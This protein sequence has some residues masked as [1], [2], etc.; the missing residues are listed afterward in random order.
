MPGRRDYDIAFVGLKPGEHEFHY[1]I[2]DKFFADRPEQEFKNCRAHVKLMLDKH[3]SFLLLKFEVGGHVDLLC[4][5]CGN[6]LTRELWDDFEMAVKMAENPDELNS[7]DED[8]DVFYI[9]RTESHINVADWLYEF[10][11]LSIPNQRTC[12][13]DDNGESTCNR[14]VLDMLKQMELQ[15]Q[16]TKEEN[17]IWKGLDKFRDS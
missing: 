14:E 6:P 4:D 13:D 7:S 12:A 9:S 3:T 2:D 11:N 15:A 5:R 1:E 10:I 8:P 16:Q 17:P